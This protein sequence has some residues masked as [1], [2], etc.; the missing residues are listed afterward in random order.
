MMSD[1]FIFFDVEKDPN[2]IKLDIEGKKDY[3][4]KRLAYINYCLEYDAEK[5]KKEIA[6]T[7]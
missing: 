3:L 1:D 4:K 7:I 2:Y 5:G 6:K